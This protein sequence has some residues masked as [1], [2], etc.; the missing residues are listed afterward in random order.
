MNEAFIQH[1]ASEFT[2]YEVCQLTILAS[3]IDKSKVT[4]EE[5]KDISC[6]FMANIKE[7]FGKV[8]ALETHFTSMFFQNVEQIAE[9]KRRAAKQSGSAPSVRRSP[10]SSVRMDSLPPDPGTEQFAKWAAWMRENDPDAFRPRVEASEPK[11]VVLNP[12][13]KVVYQKD[14][15]KTEEFF[16]DERKATLFSKLV[17]GKVFPLDGDNSVE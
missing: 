4:A 8:C 7:L 1:L 16:E 13:F 9:Q 10:Q 14:G 11:P 3:L 12:K 15:V 17:E 2:D 6:T 5:A